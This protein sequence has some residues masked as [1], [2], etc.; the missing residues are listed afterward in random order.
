MMAQSQQVSMAQKSPN[1]GALSVD[2]TPSVGD[3]DRETGSSESRNHKSIENPEKGAA[4]L[5]AVPDREDEPI[6]SMT[7]YERPKSS[8]TLNGAKLR[9]QSVQQWGGHWWMGKKRASS[10]KWRP[11]EQ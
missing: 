7:V 6:N 10:W 8:G 3:V 9:L 1:D 5:S 2:Q 4:V 11:N